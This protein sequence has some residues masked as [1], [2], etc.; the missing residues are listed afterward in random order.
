MSRGSKNKKHLPQMG[1]YIFSNGDESH[2]IETVKKSPTKETS[3]L[4][5]H[6]VSPLK[7]WGLEMMWI[8]TMPGSNSKFA[9]EHRLSRK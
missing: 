9:P 8:F 1:L 3:K 2:G 7:D 5:N 6:P 4:G